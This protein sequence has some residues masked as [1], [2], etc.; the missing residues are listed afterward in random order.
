MTPFGG[1]ARVRLQHTIAGPVLCAGVGVHGGAH[2]RLAMRPAPADHGIVF[3]RSDLDAGASGLD[4][5]IAALA[6]NLAAT[7]L[8]TTLRNAAGAEIA[9][10]EHLLAACAGL[11][12]DNLLVEIDGPEIPILDGSAAP[13][14]ELFEAAGRRSQNAPQRLIRVLSPIEVATEAGSA[15]LLPER[16]SDALTLDAAIRYRDAAIGVQ[17]LCF[18]LTPSAFV[19]EIAGARTYGFLADLDRMR[20]AGRGLGASL[21]NSVVI[22]AGRILNP[23]GL[24][25][26]DE[27]VRHKILD[28]IGDLALAGA[29][30]AG[31]YVA[32]R[33]GHALNALL[34]RALAKSRR[35]WRWETPAAEAL[36]A[37]V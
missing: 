2:A 11:E 16:G 19:A 28:A 33:P 36:A 8:G 14:V 25:F 15:A 17:K 9:T 24:R 20:A 31:R 18:A 37:A 5:R 26:A 7:H 29:P 1:E 10:I 3:V 34:V 35:A 12:I 32:D 4:N 21:Q 23:E 30:I 13:F 6:A 27:F 22:E